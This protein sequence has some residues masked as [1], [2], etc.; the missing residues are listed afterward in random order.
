MTQDER[1][2]ALID[3]DALVFNIQSIRKKTGRRMIGVV[4]AD[5][6]GHGAKQVARVMAE[7]GVDFFAVAL[8]EEALEL[9]RAGLDQPILVLDYMPASMVE[10]AV[11]EG[12]RISVVSRREAELASQAAQKLKKPAYVHFKLDTG[13]GRQGFLAAQGEKA[14]EEIRTLASMPGLVTEG[15]F[16][17]LSTADEVDKSFS[18]NQLASFTRVQEALAGMG[19]TFPMTHCANSAGIIDFEELPF[20]AVRPGIIQYGIYPSDQVNR[21]VLPL[22]PVMSLVSQV[23]F[24]KTVPAGTPIGYGRTFVTESESRI[25]TVPLGYADGINR[26]MQQGGKVWLNGCLAPVVGRVCMDQFMVDVSA[27]PEVTVGT[28]VVVFGGSLVPVSAEDVAQVWGT[29]PYE[30]TC[31]ISK[32]VPR[33]FLRNGK[34]IAEERYV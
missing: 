4:K 31:A 26:R 28:P 16:T 6:Y 22:R 33:I 15:L 7:Q 8:M 27:V 5:A 13:M 18:R 12:L 21:D 30:V 1:A 19:I 23:S 29:I 17:H 20:T 3:L 25:A 24:L 11:A 34:V 14:A 9:R 32:R 2:A 10:T